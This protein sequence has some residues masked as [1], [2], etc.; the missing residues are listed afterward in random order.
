MN[1]AK[2]KAIDIIRARGGIIR[3]QEALRKGIHRR[4]LY[5]L[6]NDFEGVPLEIR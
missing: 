1:T 4:T 6:R 2:E 3:T 5:G